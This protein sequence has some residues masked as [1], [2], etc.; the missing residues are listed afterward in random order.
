MRDFP[1]DPCVTLGAP[2][3]GELAQ[4][5]FLDFVA[6]PHHHHVGRHGGEQATVRVEQPPMTDVF[7]RILAEAGARS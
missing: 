7:R 2:V 4:A 6:F 1:L 3:G 5:D